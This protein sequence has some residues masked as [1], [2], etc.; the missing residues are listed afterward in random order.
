MASEAHAGSLGR[1]EG[2]RLAE[3]SFQ[4]EIRALQI[5]L[6]HAQ[7]MVSQL[8]GELD[9]LRRRVKDGDEAKTAVARLSQELDRRMAAVEHQREVARELQNLFMPPA[10]PQC[11]GVR[12]AV[13]YLPCERVG[14]DL[15]DVFDMGNSCIGILVADI[16]GHGLASTL[17]TAVTK[18]AF[19]TFRQNEYS[20]KAIM[21]K[22]NTQISRNTLETQFVTAF[23]G[24][25]DLETLRFKFVNASH[26]SPIVFDGDRFELLDT[27]GLCCGMFDNPRYEEKEAQLRAGDSLLF[28]TR[29]LVVT[30]NSQGVPYEN[31]RLFELV[32]ANNGRPIEQL[33][34]RVSR[35]FLTHLSGTEQYDD[36]ILVGAEIVQRET[37][38]QRIVIP[39]EPMQLARVESRILARLE[40]ENYGERVLFGVRLAL[41]E[42]VV[43]AI[44]HGNNMDKAK[45]VTITYSVDRERCRITVEDEGKGFDP[46]AV[47][48]PT[49]DENLDKPHGRGLVLIRAYMDEVRFNE[50]GNRITMVKMAPW[51]D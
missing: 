48:D 42:A 1:P 23:L 38:E 6:N 51:A 17:V 19:D 15:Y 35:D 30:R 31:T 50:K 37:R 2:A 10:L 18:M 9:E 3:G 8:R 13:K 7:N 47:P 22:V 32:R 41:E 14:G 27:D 43:N 16:S 49:M 20:P 29:G 44:K 11:D 36:V 46:F 26:P 40:E 34:D 25:L 45:K 4:E 5:E 33:V 12:F 21:E 28:Y 39:S 24:V